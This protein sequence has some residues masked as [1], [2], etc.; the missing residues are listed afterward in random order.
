MEGLAFKLR[1]ANTVLSPET[2]EKME[3][4]WLKTDLNISKVTFDFES[5]WLSSRIG[6]NWIVIISGFPEQSKY[7]SWTEMEEG[8][9]EVP[10]EN[11]LLRI[12]SP[13]DLQ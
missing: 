13:R 12:Q 9:P 2:P 11:A 7:I 4:L 6:S 1:I 3:H 5:L 10:S 8:V